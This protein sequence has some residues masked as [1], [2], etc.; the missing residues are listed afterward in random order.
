MAIKT[1]IAVKALHQPLKTIKGMKT[2]KQSEALPPKA[3][4]AMT[5][6]NAMGSVN[7]MQAMKDSVEVVKDRITEIA[8]LRVNLI[9]LLKQTLDVSR[10][11]IDDQKKLRKALTRQLVT[12]ETELLRSRV[13]DTECVALGQQ[14]VTKTNKLL[15]GS[16]KTPLTIVDCF[17]RGASTA[18]AATTDLSE[19]DNQWLEGLGR[20]IQ[21]W[22]EEEMDGV[23]EQPATAVAASTATISKP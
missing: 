7:T 18:I 22:Q 23:K 21:R 12:Q 13:S 8:R 5:S 15:Q 19:D 20:D 3:M 16:V 2:V 1:K 11:V 6:M 9:T 10:R 17:R 14:I 4:K